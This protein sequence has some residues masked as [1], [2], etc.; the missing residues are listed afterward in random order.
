MVNLGCLN[1]TVL[2][3]DLCDVRVGIDVSLDNQLPSLFVDSAEITG[4]IFVGEG[5]RQ[6]LDDQL[7]KRQRCLSLFPANQE[8]LLRFGM[9]PD[10]REHG[11]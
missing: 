11:E 5:E 1:G 9:R 10:A 3:G 2:A 7:S 4:L 6:F 8:P